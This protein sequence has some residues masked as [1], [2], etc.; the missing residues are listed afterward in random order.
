VFTSKLTRT[1][2]GIKLG[3]CCESPATNSLSRCVASLCYYIRKFPTGYLAKWERHAAL[4]CRYQTN[5]RSVTTQNSQ[6]VNCTA[7]KAWNLAPYLC[8]CHVTM[9]TITPSLY[10]NDRH[11][12]WSLHNIAKQYKF[13]YCSFKLLPV[14]FRRICSTP[15]NNHTL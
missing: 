15:N 11:L 6:D 5:L 10:S 12:I 13:L 7:A 1:E 14:Q 8:L 3:L 2:L 9:L 4:K